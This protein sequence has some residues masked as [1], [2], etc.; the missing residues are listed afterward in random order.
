M[1]NALRSDVSL[2]QKVGRGHWRHSRYQMIEPFFLKHKVHVTRSPAVSPQL[3]QQLAHRPVMWNG[4]WYRHDG[5]EPENAVFVAMYDGPAICLTPSVVVLHIVLAVAV[6]LPDIDLDALD[7]LARRR[8][9]G[10][11]H[12]KRL[13]IRVGRDREAV[14]ISG[15]IVGMERAKDGALSRVRGLGMVDGVDEKGEA[16]YV[17]KQDEL[18]RCVSIGTYWD[19]S[20][21]MYLPHVCAYLPNLC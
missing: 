13:S 19:A 7:R 21:M 1:Y 20:K 6:R 5:M 11:E 10:T 12:E 3:S 15:G 14:L 8:L 16:D 9:D 18:L 2:A 4:I 17:R